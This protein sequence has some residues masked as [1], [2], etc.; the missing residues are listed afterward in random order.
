MNNVDAIISLYAAR[1]KR[2]PLRSSNSFSQ[3]DPR[4][5]REHVRL[6]G[7]IPTH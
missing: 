6:E 2:Y 5:H 3:P 4:R 7:S 1:L